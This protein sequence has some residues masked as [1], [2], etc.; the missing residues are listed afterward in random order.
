MK[1]VGIPLEER[2]WKDIERGMKKA[3]ILRASYNV[4]IGDRLR[5]TVRRNGIDTGLRPMCRVRWMSS[6]SDGGL[7]PGFFLYEI[8]PIDAEEVKA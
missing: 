1:T 8:E 7:E 2:V 4:T 3:L 6:W 5:F